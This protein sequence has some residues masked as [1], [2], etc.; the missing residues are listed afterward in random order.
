MSLQQFDRDLIQRRANSA[1]LNQNLLTL[2]LISEH[3]FDAAD[4][5]LDTAET[6][7]RL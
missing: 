4:M 2:A 7:L 5:S 6:V 1:D 3:S